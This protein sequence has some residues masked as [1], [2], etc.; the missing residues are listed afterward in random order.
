[1]WDMMLFDPQLQ[2]VASRQ[3]TRVNFMTDKAPGILNVQSAKFGTPQKTTC[4]SVSRRVRDPTPA[5]AGFVVETCERGG[6]ADSGVEPAPP[7]HHAP[8]ISREEAAVNPLMKLWIRGPP[9]PSSVP[10][11]ETSIYRPGSKCTS[12]HFAGTSHSWPVYG[13]YVDMCVRVSKSATFPTGLFDARVTEDERAAAVDLLYPPLYNTVKG[14]VWSSSGYWRN[15]DFKPR[16]WQNA[17]GVCASILHRAMAFLLY[18]AFAKEYAAPKALRIWDLKQACEAVMHF[19]SRYG[20]L[21]RG[22]LVTRRRS[23]RHDFQQQSLNV[24]WSVRRHVPP[25]APVA[26]V[27]VSA[28]NAFRDNLIVG[29]SPRRARNAYDSQ[30]HPGLG[31]DAAKA[32]VVE[33]VEEE[34]ETWD[35]TACTGAIAEADLANLMTIDDVQLYEAEAEAEAEHYF[36]GKAVAY[37]GTYVPA[38]RSVIGEVE[39]LGPST[40]DLFNE[41]SAVFDK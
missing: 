32:V 38:A 2:V 37:N 40:L 8:P 7:T 21:V 10:G 41:L 28:Y 20:R 13:G 34:Y 39:I 25:D 16:A 35:A 31:L 22:V 23:V 3:E 30:T 36:N 5:M 33:P 12:T 26:D 14:Q 27:I 19:M 18:P 17:Y 6:D 29:D 1:M 11:V 4:T 15:A 9:R 24:V